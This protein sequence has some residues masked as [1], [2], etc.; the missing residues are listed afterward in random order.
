MKSKTF[1]LPQFPEMRTVSRCAK[2]AVIASILSACDGAGGSGP[3]Q[4]TTTYDLGGMIIGLDG[5]R[6]GASQRW[7]DGKCELWRN[8]F[9]LRGRAPDRYRL[10]CVGPIRSRL[11]DMQC[12]Q[13]RGH[14]GFL[15]IAGWNMLLNST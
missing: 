14:G 6:P 12:R 7:Y 9:S 11:S 5:R 10:F 13:R 4:N 3:G 2:I 1:V 8:V 15:V